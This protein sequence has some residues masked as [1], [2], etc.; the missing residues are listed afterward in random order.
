ERDTDRTSGQA[1]LLISAPG[2]NTTQVEIVEQ[3]Q[4]PPLSKST[5]ASHPL[6][7]ILLLCLISMGRIFLS[8]RKI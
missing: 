7:L 2:Y 6:F 5:G 4:P 8:R 3:D 1:D